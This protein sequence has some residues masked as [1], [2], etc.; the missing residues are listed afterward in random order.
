MTPLIALTQFFGPQAPTEDRMQCTLV[1]ELN[2]PSHQLRVWEFTVG[3]RAWA[4]WLLYQALPLSATPQIILLSPDGCWPHVINEVTIQTVVGRGLSL[5]WF[6]RLEM[7]WDQP[8]KARTGVL[9]HRW[10]RENWS[11]ISAWAW[12]IRQSI[13]GLLMS[14]PKTTMG[15][16]GHSRGG[17]AA[18]VAAALDHRIMAVISHNSGTGGAASLKFLSEGSEQL[19]DLATNFPHWLSESIQDPQVRQ[20]MIQCD[21][22]QHWLASIA[23]RGLCVLQAEDDH[24]ANPLGTIKMV[25]QLSPK[26]LMVP[27]ALQH[28]SRKGGHRMTEMDWQ[29]A[30]SFMVQIDAAKHVA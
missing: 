22:P 3:E 29:R 27:H 24:W 25:E 13:T 16:I 23:P 7:S 2:L 21:A 15:I 10:P 14:N 20:R 11:S 30:I 6:D 19:D 9:H 4:S 28:Y 26:W 12:G 5:A 18:L 8:S 1:H 17:K